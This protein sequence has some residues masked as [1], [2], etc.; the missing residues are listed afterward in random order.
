LFRGNLVSCT[1]VIPFSATVCLSYSTLVGLIPKGEQFATS[2]GVLRATAGATAG[3][4]ATLLTYPLDLLRT[5]L[6]VSNPVC[7]A[8]GRP[9]GALSLTRHIFRR[10]GIKG[11][12]SG[13]RPTL[14]AIAPFVAVQQATYVRIGG[15][16][17]VL[18]VLCSQPLMLSHLTH[19]H[20]LPHPLTFTP[21]PRRMY[22][23]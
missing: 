11:L 22:S 20:S 13:I 21:T 6:G 3:I 14:I 4:T 23:S 17:G 8:N 19:S 2:E 16:R 5:R 9:L 15:C 18:C 10:N 7:G 12:Y 1:R